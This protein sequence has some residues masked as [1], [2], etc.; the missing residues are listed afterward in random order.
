MQGNRINIMVNGALAAVFI[1]GLTTGVINKTPKFLDLRPS[2]P[3]PIKIMRAV[4]YHKHGN[5]SVLQLDLHHPRPVP[6]N[7]QV[8]VQVM[9][10]ALNPV[11]F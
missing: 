10:S 1:V 5:A 6:R 7:G 4:V 2:Q 3:D 9:A 11:D 8:L